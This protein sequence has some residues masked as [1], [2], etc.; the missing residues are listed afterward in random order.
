MRDPSAT[1]RFEH[2][3]SAA[4]EPLARYL[5]RR[6]APDA[7]EDLFAEVMTTAWRR[8]DDIPA[9]AE[10]PWLYGTARRVLA[11]HR[12]A[13]GRLSRLM[14]RLSLVAPSG[15]LGP[16]PAGAD[17]DLA[18][19]MAG[20]A[21]D[22]AEVLRLWAWED[23]AP[24]EIAVVMGITPNAASIRLHR[25]KA[26]LRTRLERDT[27]TAAGSAANQHVDAGKM[28]PVAG[29]LPGVERKEAR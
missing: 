4:R 16:L 29:H 22:D 21:P 8:L 10:V 7:V 1:P 2:L 20:L 19:A 24:R 12:R 6:A 13:N 9:D 15:D 5:A 11:N 18:S 3:Y 28:V 25:A 14:E 17:L 23:L 27:E 26:R